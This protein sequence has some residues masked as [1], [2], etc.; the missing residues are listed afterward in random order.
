VGKPKGII[1]GVFNHENIIV[2]LLKGVLSHTR[3]PR[4]FVDPYFVCLSFVV[5]TTTR[6]HGNKANTIK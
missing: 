5:K 1:V 2:G 6:I 3:C 4:E